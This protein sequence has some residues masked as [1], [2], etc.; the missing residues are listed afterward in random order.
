LPAAYASLEGLENVRLLP[1]ERLARYTSLRVGGP[2]DVLAIP[3]DEP[4]LRAVL[5]R[6]REGGFPL[7]ILGGGTNTLVRDG[8]IRGVVIKLG[9]KFRYVRATG[10]RVTAGAA[11]PLPQLCLYCVEHGLDGMEWAAGV[12]GTV[13]GGLVMNAGAHEEDM[14][15]SVE[16]VRFVT[17]DGETIT[18]R[19][20]EIVWRYRETELP[21]GA[22]PIEA[23]FALSK[24]DSEALRAARLALLAH[25]SATQPI[26]E[27]SCGSTFRNPP[28]H[29][30]ARLIEACGLKGHRIGGVE[31]SSKHANFFI[32]SPG[33]TASD[34]IALM[35]LVKRSVRE[36]F[37]IDLIAE[38]KVVGDDLPR[39]GADA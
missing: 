8:G 30:A 26:G 23:T 28:G 5:A 29:H 15:M 39:E 3:S 27:P 14:S 32:T 11:T 10:A 33:A 13:G 2:A 20:D 34:V 7:H 25:R 22:I 16:E 17:L 4:A 12:P 37:G 18:R 19:A 36:K 1:N 31:I 35:D 24:G 21:R 9:Q 38:V 6:I